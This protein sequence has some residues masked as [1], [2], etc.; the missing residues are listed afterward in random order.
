VFRVI[1]AHSEIRDRLRFEQLDEWIG[2]INR[3]VS[4][5]DALG[6]AALPAGPGLLPREVLQTSCSKSSGVNS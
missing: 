6:T 4:L 3:H 5:C 2:P 1:G